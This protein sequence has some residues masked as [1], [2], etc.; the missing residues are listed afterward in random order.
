L[1]DGGVIKPKE[2]ISNYAETE[3]AFPDKG[4]VAVV[5]RA[6]ED[7]ILKDGEIDIRCG[8][9]GKT[10]GIDA[11][12]G[13]VAFN[14]TDPAYVQ[15]RYK[16]GLTSKKT[17]EANS[18]VNVVGDK[19]NLISHKDSNHFNLTDKK[20]LI[21]TEDLDEIM[22]KLHQVPYG[23]VLVEVLN[24]IIEAITNHVHSYPGNPP[25]NDQYI[26]TLTSTDVNEILSENV[27][28]S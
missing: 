20:E 24:K 11:L 26:S 1:L 14:S 17:Q 2:R 27:R 8:I 5:G 12:N 25:C 10:Y 13:N 23:D 9:R 19:I 18:I 15:M 28:I 16:S 21:K 22:S 3:G 4:D 6:T 7:I